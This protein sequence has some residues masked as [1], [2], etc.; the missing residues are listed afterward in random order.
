MIK[1]QNPREK[2]VKSFYAFLIFPTDPDTMKIYVACSDVSCMKAL[3]ILQ[4]E[5]TSTPDHIT[6][7]FP[8]KFSIKS[9]K[10]FPNEQKATQKEI[11]ISFLIH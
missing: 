9:S 11:M 2:Q 1:N 7:Y 4:L 6:N 3:M 5:N 8:G 10:H